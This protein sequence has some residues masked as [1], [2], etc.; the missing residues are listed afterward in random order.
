MSLGKFWMVLGVGMP[1]VRHTSKQAAKLEAERLAIM[2][3]GEDFVVLE[4]L[5]TCRKDSVQWELN[6]ED[7]GLS[8][9]GKSIPF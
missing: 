6:D 9:L 4:S 5:A 3:P 2:N 8:E 7:E 1:R